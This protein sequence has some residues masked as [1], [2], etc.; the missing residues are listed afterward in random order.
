MKWLKS[1]AFSVLFIVFIGGGIAF[2]AHKATNK[3]N[4][5]TITVEDG[6]TAIVQQTSQDDN[7]GI[8][9]NAGGGYISNKDW[10]IGGWISKQF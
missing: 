9:L 10:F 7:L 4:H 3:E 1:K 6:G 2:L 5:Q 8:S